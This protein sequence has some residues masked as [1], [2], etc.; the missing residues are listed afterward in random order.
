MKTNE[1]EPL[2]KY[3]KTWDGVKTELSQLARDKSRG[4]PVFCLGGVRYE[5]G[6]SMI[7]ALVWNVGTCRLDVKGEIQAEAPQ[8]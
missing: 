5:G 2:L 8:G 4:Q 1:S 3:R 7:Q 6:V